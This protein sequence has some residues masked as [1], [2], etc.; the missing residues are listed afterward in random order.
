MFDDPFCHFPNFSRD[1]LEYLSKLLSS[2]AG[3]RFEGKTIFR[4]KIFHWISDSEQK[5]LDFRHTKLA[6]RPTFWS[7]SPKERFEENN[8]VK[9][10]NSFVFFNFWA[11]NAGMLPKKYWLRSLNCILKVQGFFSPHFLMFGDPFCQ[12]PF[13]SR[14]FLE[15]LSK[16]L[17]SRAEDCLEGKKSF[18]ERS[19]LLLSLAF[20]AEKV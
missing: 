5:C 17:P 11:K 7:I 20:R 10:K 14:D 3:D 8:V 1:L 9:N 2:S 16:L 12:F 15:S 19:V 13:F 4:K 18:E 6:G